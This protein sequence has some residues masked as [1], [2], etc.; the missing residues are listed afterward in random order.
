[1]HDPLEYVCTSYIYL[2]A[3]PIAFAPVLLKSFLD[4]YILNFPARK[5]QWRSTLTILIMNWTIAESYVY[6]CN[7]TQV[8]A[9]SLITRL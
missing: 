7:I 4:V 2:F 5:I 6:G 9:G 3:Y 1:M 8:M